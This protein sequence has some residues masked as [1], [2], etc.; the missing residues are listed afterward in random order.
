M[1][2]PNDELTL[3]AA[4]VMPIDRPPIQDG[5]VRLRG[6]QI[7]AVGRAAELGGPTH[8]LGHV[9]LMPGFVNAHT[10]LELTACQGRL[11][12]APFWVWVERL[13]E[14]RRRDHAERA[15]RAAIV[16]GAWQSLRAGVTCVG[17]VSRTGANVAALRGVPI[18]R[19]CFI[20]LISGA[21]SP[22]ADADQLAECVRA[23]A[24]VTD[25]LERI[26]ISPHALYSV[27]WDDLCRVAALAGER[28]LPVTM[29]AGETAEEIE[30]LRSGS[31]PV[32]VFVQRFG[33]PTAS[34]P[35]RGGVMDLL[36]R[37]RITGVRP[38]LIHMNYTNDEQLTL[39]AGSRC[40][41][42]YC[43][44]T[45]AFFGHPPHRWREM[46]ARGVNV[47][48][49]TDSLAS[50]STL[51]V[52]DELRLL[53]L[54]AP[55]VPAAVLL[56]MATLDAAR[57]LGIADACGSLTAGKQADIVAVSCEN[58]KDWSTGIGMFSPSARI[59]A[60]WVAG[61]NVVRNGTYIEPA[62]ASR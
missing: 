52:L 10:H 2:M 43:P 13:I 34:A 49:G 47:C 16:E 36:H 8:D 37:A 7:V 19:V 27:A 41:V 17:D 4:L 55:D 58:G 40:S 30:W 1:T 18:R 6:D 57:A 21:M 50:N 38:L 15:D 59:E 44:R 45:H 54:L 23:A 35:I 60:V 25:P 48:V 39:L 56:R 5:A 20:E 62:E 26:G 28:D 42:A 22:P 24:S 51:S 31:G 12:P 9:I 46:Q 14:L 32:A 11:A 53:H 29:H 3:R 33:L 61:R